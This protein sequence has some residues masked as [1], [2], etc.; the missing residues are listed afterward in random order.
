MEAE[1]MEMN[2]NGS[3]DGDIDDNLGNYPKSSISNSNMT[4]PLSSV[5][6]SSYRGSNFNENIDNTD[7]LHRITNNVSK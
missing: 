3:G 1:L 4:S 7:S 5:H 6:A 2:G